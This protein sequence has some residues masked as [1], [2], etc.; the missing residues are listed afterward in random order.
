MRTSGT[1]KH[2]TNNDHRGLLLYIMGF[3][4]MTYYYAIINGSK[5]KNKPSIL[6][7]T[8]I[9]FIETLKK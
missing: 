2:E 5:K 8:K 9:Y 1:L 7:F 3:Q 4:L 6:N